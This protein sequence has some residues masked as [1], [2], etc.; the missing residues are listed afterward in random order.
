MKTMLLCIAIATGFFQ[1]CNEKEK[2][3]EDGE[4][5]TYLVKNNKDVIIAYIQIF[6]PKDQFFSSKNSDSSCYWDIEKKWT[7]DQAM[8]DTINYDRYGRPLL[9]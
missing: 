6:Q 8:A 3:M 5:H 7:L 1:T 2:K 9:K 4:L